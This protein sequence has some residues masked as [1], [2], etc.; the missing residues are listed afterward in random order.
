M[1]NKRTSLVHL[2][3]FSRLTIS[4][5]PALRAKQIGDITRQAQK[6]N[7]FAVITSFL[8]IDQNFAIQVVEGERQSVNETFQR[9][10]ADSRHRDVQIVEWRE[11]AKREFV[12]SFT[13]VSRTAANEPHFAKSGLLPMLQ[14]GTPKSS[15][16][17]GLAVTLQAESMAKQG[18][19]HL[20]V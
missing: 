2:I 13:T 1:K 5:E 6:K 16:I 7:E 3:Y 15:A 9:I 12:S 4:N 18:I 8:I 11:I 20:F 17:H 10:A 14:R 19:D